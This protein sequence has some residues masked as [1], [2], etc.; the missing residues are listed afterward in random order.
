MAR[1]IRIQSI[2]DF[3][4]GPII[5]VEQ[6]K[7][8]LRVQHDL[9]NADIQEIIYSAYQNVEAHLNRLI[10]KQ[11]NT[12]KIESSD[13]DFSIVLPDWHNVESIVLLQGVTPNNT[14]VTATAFSMEWPE[15]G[16]TYATLEIDDIV[17]NPIIDV[18]HYELTIQ[19]T[20]TLLNYDLNRAVYLT[21]T[22]YYENRN[23]I[24]VGTS[25][26]ELPRGAQSIIDNY[27]YQ[28]V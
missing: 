28:P 18:N 8:N 1:F 20:P 7:S 23:S 17:F 11:V 14:K 26:S 19:H 9:D 24:I 13:D 2:P 15:H 5:T 12:Y 27:K 3:T 6:A 21:I 22:H 4:H 25:A 10:L 16:Y